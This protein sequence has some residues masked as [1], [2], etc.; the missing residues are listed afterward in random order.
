MRK[1]TELELNIKQS[2]GDVASLENEV[3]RLSTLLDEVFQMLTTLSSKLENN[4]NA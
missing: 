3:A 2:R 4:E 1:N